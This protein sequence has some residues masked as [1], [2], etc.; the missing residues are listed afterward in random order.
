M[1]KELRNISV[2]LTLVFLL[3]AVLALI[4]TDSN[5]TNPTAPTPWQP[6]GLATEAPAPTP[7]PKGAGGAANRWWDEMPTPQSSADTDTNAGRKLT[8]HVS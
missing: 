4:L 2:V 8:T 7:T 1:K 5:L 6:A 3:L